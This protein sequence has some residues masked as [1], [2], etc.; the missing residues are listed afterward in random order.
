MASKKYAAVDQLQKIDQNN[1]CRLQN[2]YLSHCAVD[3]E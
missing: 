3:F 1:K 2:G